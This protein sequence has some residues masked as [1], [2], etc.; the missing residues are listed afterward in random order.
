MFPGDRFALYYWQINKNKV[1]VCGKSFVSLLNYSETVRRIA[2]YVDQCGMTWHSRC[3]PNKN[4]RDDVV[5]AAI[6]GQMGATNVAN[7]VKP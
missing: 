3:P 2:I 5:D 6:N 7:T 1:C 4:Q